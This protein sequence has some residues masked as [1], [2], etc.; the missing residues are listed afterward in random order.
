MIFESK[1]T[2]L[3]ILMLLVMIFE[4]I[5]IK[6]ELFNTE[7]NIKIY[8]FI[9][10]CLLILVYFFKTVV[11][12]KAHFT[13]YI[14]DAITIISLLCLIVFSVILIRGKMKIK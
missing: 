3:F 10:S 11:T 2:L 14:Y 12:K 7:E 8:P 1:N 5:I 9:L 13:E 4:L 6:Y